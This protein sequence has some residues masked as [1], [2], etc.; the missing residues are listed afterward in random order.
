MVGTG[1]YFFEVKKIVE[2]KVFQISFVINI[3]LTLV[4]GYWDRCLVEPSQFM[5]VSS[6]A[7]QTP[8]VHVSI[9][10]SRAMIRFCSA[11]RPNTRN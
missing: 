7:W 6:Q 5:K 2:L 3:R 10:R 8:T 1:A 4:L 11:A 9:F